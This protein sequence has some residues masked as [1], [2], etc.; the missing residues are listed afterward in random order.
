MGI[1]TPL[2]SP[3]HGTSRHVSNLFQAGF[4]ATAEPGSS[5]LPFKYDRPTSVYTESVSLILSDRPSLAILGIAKQC[6]K[7][8]IV[9]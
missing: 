4:D 6:V 2:E 7:N 3:L 5:S 8:R 1:S 9:T